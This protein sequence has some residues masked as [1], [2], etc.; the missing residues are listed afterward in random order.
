MTEEPA[1]LLRR[2]ADRVEQLAAKASHNVCPDWVYGAVRHIA[3]N[4][5]ITCTHTGFGAVAPPAD[6]LNHDGWD[7]YDD[8]PWISALGPQVAAPLAAWLRLTADAYN[9]YPADVSDN[10]LS[11]PLRLARVILGEQESEAAAA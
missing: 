7:R 6:G 3:R 2:A 8:S 1:D 9:Q 5:D 10:D 4:C 11:E